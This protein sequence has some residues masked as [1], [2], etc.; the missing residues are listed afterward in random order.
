MEKAFGGGTIEARRFWNQFD[1][2]DR[3]QKEVRE[4]GTE[5]AGN[6]GCDCAIPHLEAELLGRARAAGLICL[7]V[8]TV[9]IGRDGGATRCVVV[10]ILDLDF[11]SVG[12]QETT[13]VVCSSLVLS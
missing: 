2:D 12:R 6:G 13:V 5:I 7:E 8:L 10:D 3:R 4:V 1:V 9:F 11:L